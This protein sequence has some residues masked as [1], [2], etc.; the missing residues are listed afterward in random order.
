M[1]KNDLLS[2]DTST[3]AGRAELSLALGEVFSLIDGSC[4]EC[5]HL[6]NRDICMASFPES[7]RDGCDSWKPIPIDLDDWAVA[8]RWRDWAVGEYGR[9]LFCRMLDKAML[10]VT[11][12][13]HMELKRACDAK[14][15]HY[16]I[17]A[18]TCKL[19]DK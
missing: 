13:C 16:L 1:N 3:D 7:S 2:Q 17:A 18:A 12:N 14:S 10:E 5:V 15:E 8:V 19:T 9:V 6:K 4:Y 11:N